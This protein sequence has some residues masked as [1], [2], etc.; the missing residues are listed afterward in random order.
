MVI[1]SSR[2]KQTK[3]YSIGGLED[4]LHVFDGY[5]RGQLACSVFRDK[6]GRMDHGN[7]YEEREKER[8]HFCAITH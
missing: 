8:E 6:G 7:P 2:N 5:I 1:G 3:R 4:G